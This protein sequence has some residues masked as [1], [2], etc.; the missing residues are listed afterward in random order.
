MQYRR[1]EAAATSSNQQPASNDMVIGP[2]PFD[3]TQEKILDG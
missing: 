1:P 3:S 2:S